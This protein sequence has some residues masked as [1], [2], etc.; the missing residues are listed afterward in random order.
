MPR[1]RRWNLK[2]AVYHV[3]NRLLEGLP[4]VPRPFMT[5]FILGVMARGQKIHPGV[6]IHCFLWMGNHYHMVISGNPRKFRDYL[7]YIEGEIAFAVNRMLGRRGPLWDGRYSCQL[8]A[9][10]RDVI[11]MM[12]YIF[13]NPTRAGLVY[14]VKQW[15]GANSWGF[16][17]KAIKR[18]ISVFKREFKWYR[19]GAV[20]Y[21]KKGLLP[22]EEAE[23]L[24]IWDSKVEEENDLT[25]VPFG[26]KECFDEVRDVSDEALFRRLLKEIKR[27]EKEI[28]PGKKIRG[29]HILKVSCMHR[30]YKSKKR[31]RTPFIICMYDRELLKA[32]IEQYKE[33]CNQCDYCYEEY[34]NGNRSIVFPDGAFIPSQ[35]SASINLGGDFSE[36]CKDLGFSGLPWNDTG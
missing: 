25:V 17:K 7:G 35:P 13:L 22:S 27:R 3:T 14:K 19:K 8:L 4:F 29:P 23:I 9:T 5:K 11:C 10:W 21:I 15:G 26:W 2:N 33:F 31:E 16:M 34:K 1:N 18:G 20:G 32:L 36:L 28:L 12:A 30:Q 6:T 24:R